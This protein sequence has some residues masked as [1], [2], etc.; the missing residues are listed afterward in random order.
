MLFMTRCR[1][2]RVTVMAVNRLTNT[3]IARV[4]AKPFT[5]LCLKFDPNQ[6]RITQVMSVHALESRMEGQAWAKPVSIVVL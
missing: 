1:K 2:V 6:N 4:S 3:P 5:M